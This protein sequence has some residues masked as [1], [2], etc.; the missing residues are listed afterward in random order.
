[1]VSLLEDS[2]ATIDDIQVPDQPQRPSSTYSPQRSRGKQGQDR[3]QIACGRVMLLADLRHPGQMVAVRL[4]C[5]RK[6]CPSCGPR[7]RREL[8]EHYTAKIGHLPVTSRMIQRSAWPTLAKRLQRAGADYV[9]IP[10]P[11]RTYLV[12]ATIGP[13]NVVDDVHEVL[14]GAFRAMPNDRAHVT[15]SRD[16]AL[17]RKTHGQLGSEQPRWE[18]IGNAAVPYPQVIKAALKLGLHRRALRDDELQAGWAQADLLHQPKRTSPAWRAFA[19]R[20]GLHWP[21]RAR[22][23]SRLVA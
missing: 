8:A 6:A 22:A 9:R 13:G 7:L 17:R 18:L 10:Q 20:I 21:G 1:V 14:T 15:S 4:A 12:L 23:E 19:E 3:S 2:Y 5:D 16:W 11:G